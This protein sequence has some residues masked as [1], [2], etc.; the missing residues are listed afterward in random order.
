MSSTPASTGPLARPPRAVPW[1]LKLQLYF[2]SAQ[3]QLLWF[4]P[5][6]SALYLALMLPDARLLDAAA[7]RGATAEAEAEVVARERIRRE[8]DDD[9]NVHSRW[10]YSYRFTDAAGAAWEGTSYDPALTLEVGERAPVEYARDRPRASRLV[11]MSPHREPP[12]MLLVALVMLLVGGVPLVRGLRVAHRGARLLAIGRRVEAAPAGREV[13]KAGRGDEPDLVRLRFTFETPGG[14]RSS[15]TVKTRRPAPL[16][17]EGLEALLVDPADRS[18]AALIDELNGPI[19]VDARGALVAPGLSALRWRRAAERY[20]IPQRA[21]GESLLGV[22]MATL[23]QPVIVWLVVFGGALFVEDALAGTAT[24]RDAAV[25]LIVG[26]LC[27]VFL[28][29]CARST[30][31]SLRS[32][33]PGAA[34]WQRSLPKVFPLLWLIGAIAGGVTAA[35]ALPDND[36]RRLSLGRS[37]CRD[38]LSAGLPYGERPDPAALDACAPEGAR[39]RAEHGDRTPAE[40]EARRA[41]V[42]SA[43]G[44]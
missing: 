5:V 37:L 25:G 23:A 10:A 33:M 11:G 40:R 29:V 26:G 39:C 42:R 36:P 27:A 32:P 35:S 4:L 34:A 44:L 1:S 19:L 8:R 18:R 38:V 9:G 31:R 30:W 17:D 7:L 12:A 16:E 15:Y 13:V 21:A 2:G 28:G 14:R 41:C 6:I 43:L 24:G 22:V 3:A 20:H